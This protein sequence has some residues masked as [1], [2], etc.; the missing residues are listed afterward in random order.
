MQSQSKT[1]YPLGT[2]GS[3]D[4]QLPIYD[5]CWRNTLLLINRDAVNGRPGMHLPPPS[6][7]M[8]GSAI[9]H[10]VFYRIMNHEPWC[11]IV[12]NIYCTSLNLSQ[13]FPKSVDDIF[14]EHIVWTHLPTELTH[15][16]KREKMCMSRF[17]RKLSQTRIHTINCASH[18][19]KTENKTWFPKKCA[20]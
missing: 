1:A 3:S 18:V 17:T 20:K 6:L 7:D 16:N 4:I 14:F 19:K 15:V 10:R 5:P 11:D 13:W 2:V 9:T 12:V 8:R